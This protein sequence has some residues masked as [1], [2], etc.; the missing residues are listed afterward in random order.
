MNIP[1]LLYH[2][3]NPSREITPEIFDLH[4]KFLKNSGF[5]SI[6]L[7]EMLEILSEK[8]KKENFIAITFD[9]G[10]LD[11]YIFAFPILKK[12]GFKA[13]IFVVTE[14][15]LEENA[16]DFNPSTDSFSERN[17]E[18]LLSWQQMREMEKNGSIKIEPHTHTHFGYDKYACFRNLT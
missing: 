14:N 3:I 18:N 16:S 1:V 11:N 17:F 15:I 13:T 10:Y 9:D 4:I 7:D 6:F 8:N 5:K 2:H 12:Y